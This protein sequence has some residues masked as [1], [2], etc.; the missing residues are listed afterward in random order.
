MFLLRLCY[1]VSTTKSLLQHLYY[2]IPT[3]TSLLQRPYYYYNVPTTTTL[4]QR[5]LVLEK[6]PEMVNLGNTRLHFTAQERF[7]ILHSQTTL[8]QTVCSPDQKNYGKEP[9][10]SSLT[11]SG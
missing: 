4:V 11:F 10:C 7:Q 1:N 5:H 6:G 9:Y 2:N 3:T 8:T